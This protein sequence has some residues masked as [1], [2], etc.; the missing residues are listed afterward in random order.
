M[1]GQ[2]RFKDFARFVERRGGSSPEST[3]GAVI[4]A[5]SSKAS[6]G[7]DST[8]S[9]KTAKTC[10]TCEDDERVLASPCWKKESRPLFATSFAANEGDEGET[11]GVCGGSHF[12]GNCPDVRKAGP[13]RRRDLMG[14]AGVCFVCLRLGHSARECV[15]QTWC[16]AGGCRRRHHTILHL[17]QAEEQSSR[18]P[19]QGLGGS[20]KRR[21]GPR[22][23]RR[24]PAPE[25]SASGKEGTK[26]RA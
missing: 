16:E 9:S 7:K 14:R 8:T 11:C 22:K 20:P 2:V 3:L 24:S 17:N 19:G 26:R 6:R 21:R 15:Q 12:I 4:K 10:A 25:T 23:T 13:K 18:S 5:G 1:D